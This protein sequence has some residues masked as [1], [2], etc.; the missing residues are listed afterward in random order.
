M[1]TEEQLRKYAQGIQES[2]PFLGPEDRIAVH[3]LN[4]LLLHHSVEKCYEA[5]K[6]RLRGEKNFEKRIVIRCFL[7]Y[8]NNLV[9][10][11]PEVEDIEDVM[12]CQRLHWAD[13]TAIER[14]LIQLY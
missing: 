1:R 5:L 13:R 10:E 11:E 9:V 7:N 8:I 2:G 4:E 14:D 3:V 12:E 6:K